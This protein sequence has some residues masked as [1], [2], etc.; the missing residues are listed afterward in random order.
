MTEGW[1]RRAAA[2]SE[3]GGRT[4]GDQRVS[5]ALVS[6]RGGIASA[7]ARTNRYDLACNEWLVA[8]HVARVVQAESAPP[9]SR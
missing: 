9:V 6:A 1:A 7:G 5:S 2:C 3:R 8:E 4:R